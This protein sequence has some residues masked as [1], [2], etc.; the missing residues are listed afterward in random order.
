MSAA[1]RQAADACLHSSHRVLDSPSDY[2]QPFEEALAEVVRNTDSKYL[3]EQDEVKL[4]F[5]G[6]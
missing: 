1:S 4:G 6:R 3:T 2:I 5:S